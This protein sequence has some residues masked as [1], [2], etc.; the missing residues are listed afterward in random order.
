MSGVES[1]GNVTN[2]FLP[3]GLRFVRVQLREED[4]IAKRD[5]RTRRTY[6][7]LKGA[8]TSGTLLPN[9]HLTLEDLSGAL[10]VS[11]TPIREALIRL[12]AEDL[13]EFL[14]NRGFFV[15]AVDVVELEDLYEFARALLR[16]SARRMSRTSED[17]TP[18]SPIFESS[19]YNHAAPTDDTSNTARFLED[20]YLDIVASSGS[21]TSKRAIELFN[22]RTHLFRIHGL[23]EESLLRAVSTFAHDIYRH[24]AAGQ[25]E[26]AVSSIDKLFDY[27]ISQ[28]TRI[29]QSGY[30][31]TLG[32]P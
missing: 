16:H 29:W 32:G 20:F 13:V 19:Q 5:D 25:T 24:L 17:T 12:E 26:D 14:P 18:S 22:I 31:Q 30:R 7:A 8:I 11:S 21:M 2:V 23:E 6:L 27:K 9:Q 28:I 10:H 4:V 15:R 1:F 3:F